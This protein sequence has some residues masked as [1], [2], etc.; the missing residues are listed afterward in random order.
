MRCGRRRRYLR[1]WLQPVLVGDNHR[2]PDGGYAGLYRLETG[3]NFYQDS[4]AENPAAFRPEWIGRLSAY[5]FGLGYGTDDG[6]NVVALG[7][8]LKWNDSRELAFVAGLKGLLVP[9][10]PKSGGDARGPRAITVAKS[11]PKLG[12]HSDRW[13]PSGMASVY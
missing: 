1:V 12:A 6:L 11:Q 8:E 2:L 5:P 7:G 3:F 13:L 9:D 10:K 4:A